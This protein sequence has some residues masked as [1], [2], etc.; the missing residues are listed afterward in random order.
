MVDEWILHRQALHA[1]EIFFLILCGHKR[2]KIPL[3]LELQSI[4]TE[5][6]QCGIL[7]TVL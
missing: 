4:V 7:T 1:Y 5:K 6:N 3:P 2:I